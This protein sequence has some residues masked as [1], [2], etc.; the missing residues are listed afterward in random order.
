MRSFYCSANTKDTLN[1]FIEGNP[2]RVSEIVDKAWKQESGGY[3]LVYRAK[4]SGP[5]RIIAIVDHISDSYFI[6][7]IHEGHKQDYKTLVNVHSMRGFVCVHVWVA[8]SD[9]CCGGLYLSIIN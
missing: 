1:Y 4:H 7:K 9:V 3:G 8:P 2:K 5:T 6:V